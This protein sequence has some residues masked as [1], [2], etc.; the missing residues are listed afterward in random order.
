M[1]VGSLVECIHIPINNC[2]NEQIPIKGDTYVIRDIV[3]YNNVVG[4]RVEEIINP[5]Y[6]YSCGFMECVFVIDNF[7]EL[8]PPMDISELVEESISLSNKCYA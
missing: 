4:I 5:E 1:Q 3:E 7:R 2:Y 8:Q 6:H